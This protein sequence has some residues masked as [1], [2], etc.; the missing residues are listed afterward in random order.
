MKKYLAILSLLITT[1]SIIYTAEQPIQQERTPLGEFENIPPSLRHEMFENF[2]ESELAALARTSKALHDIVQPILNE[3]L[4]NYWKSKHISS[5]TLIDNSRVTSLSFSPNGKLLASGSED[6]SVKLWNAATREMISQLQE[7]DQHG[8]LWVSTVQ[9][10]PNGELLASG[11]GRRLGP[12][13]G[14]VMLWP[15][16]KRFFQRLREGL[17]N[18]LY[19]R[20]Y[21][22]IGCR[23]NVLRL[24]FSPNGQLLAVGTNVSQTHLWDLYRGKQKG[25]FG[26]K[27]VPKEIAFSRDGATLLRVIGAG[28]WTIEAENITTEQRETIDL[29]HRHKGDMQLALFSPDRKILATIQE[30]KKK[31]NIILWNAATGEKIKRFVG[32]KYIYAIAFSPDG[33]ILAIGSDDGIILWNVS[34]GQVINQIE[35][36]N[37]HVLVFSPDGKTLASSAWDGVIRLWKAGE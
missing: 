37:V 24:S 17:L 8:D 13:K 9:F 21:K 31:S 29:K 28:Y 33:N 34:T 1:T 10:S 11:S 27:G 25:E 5:V 20:E 7:P 2:S 26:E 18:I 16:K 22:K 3:R 4:I 36:K 15:L 32:N 6:N 23:D 12:A 14:M 19:D 30:L 35:T